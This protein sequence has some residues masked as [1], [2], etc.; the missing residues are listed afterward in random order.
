VPTPLL[1]G[2]PLT[3]GKPDLSF[4]RQPEGA[5]R[6]GELQAVISHAVNLRADLPGQPEERTPHRDRV[7][8]DQVI[9]TLSACQRSRVCCSIRSSCPAVAHLAH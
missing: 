8:V 6:A 9:V 2:G 1:L 7:G 4:R 5:G 3:I